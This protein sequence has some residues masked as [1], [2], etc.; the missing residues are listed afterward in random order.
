MGYFKN[1]KLNNFRNLDDYYIEFSKNCNV[2]YGENGCGKTN[3]LEALSLCTKG[4]GIRKDKI[5]NFIKKEES[6]FSN[7]AYFVNENI[8]YEIKVISEL[9]NNKL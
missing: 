2:F 1:I 8:E 6:S 3:L 5:I 7:I 4:R 9:S